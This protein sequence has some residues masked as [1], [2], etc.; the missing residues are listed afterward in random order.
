[1]DVFRF[2]DLE[3]SLDQPRIDVVRN[4]AIELGATI[5]NSNVTDG[6]AVIGSGDAAV[7]R[8]YWS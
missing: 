4:H 3:K 6:D 8:A 5:S 1:L 2:A 7:G